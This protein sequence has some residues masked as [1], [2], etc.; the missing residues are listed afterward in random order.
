MQWR[1]D[2]EMVREL[3]VQ[4]Y[5][6]SIAWVRILP[7]GFIDKINQHGIHYYNNIINECLR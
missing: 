6:F 7:S 1:R 3:G 2:I 4:V 5:R